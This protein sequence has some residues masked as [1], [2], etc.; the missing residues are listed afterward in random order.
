MDNMDM[1][2][3]MDKIKQAQAKVDE[4]KQRLDEVTFEEKSSDGLLNVTITGNREVKT[5]EV[6]DKLLEDK[7]QLEDYL[8]V[9][10][11]KAVQK[12]HEKN[13]EELASAARDGMP[14]IPGM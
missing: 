4:A 7:E 5:I 13:E 2:G 10:L 12:A 9:T 11:N 8:V 3:M 6:D 14:N 1:S